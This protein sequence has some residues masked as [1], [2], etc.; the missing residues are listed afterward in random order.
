[1]VQGIRN[2]D[3]IEGFLKRQFAGIRRMDFGVRVPRSRLQGLGRR[4]FY[5]DL[6]ATVDKRKQPARAAPDFENG[7]R[8]WNDEV[9]VKG[10][11]FA[12][13]NGAALFLWWDFLGF[14]VIGHVQNDR[15]F[16]RFAAGLAASEM[17]MSGRISPAGGLG[18]DSGQPSKA[19]P[20]QKTC[21]K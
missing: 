9:Q 15:S 6:A 20:P 3:V 7:S 11:F 19:K 2:D 17:R 1:M 12:V 5:A 10:E 4:R 13:G 21:S 18:K 8:G 14:E 16:R